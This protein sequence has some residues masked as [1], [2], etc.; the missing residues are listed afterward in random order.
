MLKQLLAT[1]M[2]VLPL[3]ANS[4]LLERLGGLA[5]YDDVADLTWLAD[6]NA[7]AGSVYDN[8]VSTTDGLMPMTGQLV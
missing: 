7:G 1:C 6:A 3:T 8:G 2:I 5:Y 4:A